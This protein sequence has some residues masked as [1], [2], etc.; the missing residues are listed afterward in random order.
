MADVRVWM[1]MG[2]TLKVS[3]EQAKKLLGGDQA[4]LDEI[5]KTEGAWSFDGDSYIPDGIV[6]E[7]RIALELNQADY[8]GEVN[9]EM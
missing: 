3:E 5:I 9:F 1:R 8:R 2:V 7:L 4:T 6:E